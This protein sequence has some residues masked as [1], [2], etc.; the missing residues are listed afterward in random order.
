MLK[1][2]HKIIEKNLKIAN[3]YPHTVRALDKL[4]LAMVVWLRLE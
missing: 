4:N 2:D 3:I 1:Y